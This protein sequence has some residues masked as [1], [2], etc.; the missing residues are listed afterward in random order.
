M[1]YE[2]IAERSGRLIYPLGR[3]GFSVDL[4][5]GRLIVGA[6]NSGVYMDGAITLYEAIN[7]WDRADEVMSPDSDFF[8]LASGQFGKSVA[9]D[10]RSDLLLVGDEDGSGAAHLYLI[11]DGELQ[12]VY[13]DY[14]GLGEYGASV[15]IDNKLGVIGSPTAGVGGGIRIL[16]FSSSLVGPSKISVIPSLLPGENFGRAVAVSRDYIVVGANKA[17]E[18]GFEVGRLYIYRRAPDGWALHQELAPQ[19]GAGGDAYGESVAIDGGTIVVGAPSSGSG[20]AAYIY[21]LVNG[22]WVLDQKLVSDISGASFGSSVDIQGRV[23]IVGAKRTQKLWAEEGAAHI[24]KKSAVEGWIL[25]QSFHGAGLNEGLGISVAIEGAGIAIGRHGYLLGRGAADVYA[26]TGL[27]ADNDGRP[28][29]NDAFPDDP[30]EQWD[31]DYDGIGDEQDNCLYDVN[32]GQKD[33][34]GDG[35]GNV[36]DADDDGDGISDAADNCPMKANVNQSDIDG[37]SLGDACD[38]DRDGDGYPNSTDVFP[39]DDS[40]WSDLDN[41]GI[42]DNDDPDRDGDGYANEYDSQPDVPNN[43]QDIDGDGILNSADSDMDGDGVSNELDADMDG[44]GFYND[45]DAFPD[46]SRVWSDLDGDGVG[47]RL[48][49][50]RDGDGVRNGRDNSPDSIS[51]GSCPS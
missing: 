21:E 48:D 1:Q 22:Q 27:D 30:E 33:L 2:K 6:P 10:K 19:G 38:S 16:D 9:L 46:D 50:D 39:D 3:F 44:D 34:D 49:P 11:G 13:V 47:D 15:A 31:I 12:P 8:N 41:D 37:D 43:W 4:V 32:S 36:C 7:N 23:I 42:G 25:S 20:G 45:D 14:D 40:E 17:L 29:F 18:N 28:D 24:Y 26:Y 51:E 35:L 5:G